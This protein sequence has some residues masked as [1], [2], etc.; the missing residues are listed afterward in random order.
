MLPKHALRR[1]HEVQTRSID[2]FNS[3]SGEYVLN[4]VTLQRWKMY[5]I[6]VILDY[7]IDAVYDASR[8]F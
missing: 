6:L 1:R 5:E 2:N 3:L 4:K 7:T 8:V